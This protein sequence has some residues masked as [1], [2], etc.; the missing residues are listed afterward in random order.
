M[1]FNSWMYLEWQFFNR[2]WALGF[3]AA[4]LSAILQL[5]LQEIGVDHRVPPLV[6]WG[7]RKSRFETERVTCHS[8]PEPIDRIDRHRPQTL[9]SQKP[10]DHAKVLLGWGFIPQFWWIWCDWKCQ[11]QIHKPC[12]LKGLP[13]NRDKLLWNLAPSIGKLGVYESWVN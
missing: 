4:H 6:Q 9:C 7:A 11:P 2:L 5:S 13:P 12:L 1:R 3:G 10:Y 8:G